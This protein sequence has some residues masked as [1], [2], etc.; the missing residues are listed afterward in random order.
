MAERKRVRDNVASAINNAT[1]IGSITASPD[2]NVEVLEKLREVLRVPEGE[3]IVTH[4]K[5]IRALA[6]AL[7]GLQKAERKRVRD[8]VASAIN[9][10]TWIGSITASPDPNVEVLEKL[11]E[12]LR[13]PEGENIVTH[14]KVIR[15]LADALIGLQKA[16]RKR[17]RDNVAS[18]INNATWIGSITASPD[19]NVEVL[20]KLREVLRV[21]E[22][23]NIVTHA[24][25]IRALADALIGLQK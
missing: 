15:A 11:R 14:A 21:P 1:W 3:N 12:V 6:D 18:A 23:E 7:I 24:K 25:V 8:N 4:A 9:N 5:V 22:G 10:A 2:P 13:V 17:V 19:P 16:E 20:E